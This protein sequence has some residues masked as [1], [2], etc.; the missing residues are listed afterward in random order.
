MVAPL[1]VEKVPFRRRRS[2]TPSRRPVKPVI[3]LTEEPVADDER[4]SNSVASAPRPHRPPLPDDWPEADRQAFADEVERGRLTDA[5]LVDWLAA[6]GHAADLAFVRRARGDFTQ[7]LSDGSASAT[8]AT[9]IEGGTPAAT[10]RD[11]ARLQQR[12]TE[13]IYGRLQVE[14]LALTT[15][16]WCRM[17]LRVPAVSATPT[18]ARAL[19]SRLT[20]RGDA[21]GDDAGDSGQPVTARMMAERIRDLLARE[22]P[23]SAATIGVEELPTTSDPA[24]SV[25]T[26]KSQPSAPTAGSAGNAERPSPDFFVGM[27]DSSSN[28]DN[29]S[30]TDHTR[31]MQPQPRRVIA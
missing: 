6:R 27:S 16:Q 18:A 14:A 30:E 25:E 5:E 17:L 22:L 26:G 8:I 28:C 23:E 11:G 7:R 9:V 20:D 31:G 24:E 12:L 4:M 2:K 13:S 1:R 10:P 29:R 21:A 15:E 3:R 19:R